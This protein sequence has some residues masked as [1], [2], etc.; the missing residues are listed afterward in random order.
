MARTPTS[1]PPAGAVA[2]DDIRWLDADK[3]YALS[4]DGGKLVCRNPGGKRLS[5]VPKEL[6]ESALAEQLTAL[7]EWLADHRTE[8]LRRVETWMLRSLPVPCDVVR[9]VW[10]DPDW[11]D[12]LRN[13]VVAPVD[14]K[15]RTDATRTGLF[16]DVDPK[17][18]VGVVDRDGETKWLAAAQLL[19]PHPIL[20][21]GVGELREIAAD[22]GF[23][24]AL[25]QLFRPIFCADRRATGADANRGL[26][27]WEIRAA[28]LCVVAVPAARLSRARRL[29]L[30]QGLGERQA[31]RGAL[32]D[33]RRISG[34]G[35]VHRRPYFCGR[36]PEAAEDRQRGPRDLQRGDEDGHADF[37]EAH[38]REAGRRRRMS[39][40]IAQL[41][42]GGLVPAGV[43][44]DADATEQIAARSYRHPALGDR[45]VIRLTSDRLGQAE[46]LAMEFLGFA[47]PAVSEP[48]ARQQRRSLGFAAWAL[49]N[50]PANARYALDLVKR[51]KAAARQARSKPGHAWD[52]Y[53]EMAKELGKSVRQFLPPFWEE[54]G[55]TFKDIGNQTYAGRALNKSLEAERV[56][57]LESDRARRRDVVLEFVLSGCL[58]GSAL[59]D[60]GN[61]LLNHYPAAEAFAIFRDLCVRRTRGGMAPWATLPKDFAKLAGAA[62]LDADQELERW[63]EEVIEAPAMGRTPHQFWKT[64][65]SHCKRIVARNPAFAVA[66][67]RHTRPE[68]RH[69]GESKLGPWFELL[70]EWGVLDYLWQDEHRGAPPLGEPIAHW[71]ARIVHDEVPAPERT[72]EMLEK[73]APRLRGEDAAPARRCPALRGRRD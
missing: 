23:T 15:G 65:S 61:D 45:P 44:G 9:A 60:Y 70:E 37:R 13:L 1:P 36:K 16:R 42:A 27:Q 71:F 51:M 31:D 11:R 47:A 26:Q 33:R 35:N 22:M 25:E 34:S 73:L 62:E 32:L 48:I 6:K 20:I 72:L 55:R 54:V 12:M 50:D 17:K 43:K 4:I 5:S 56:H 7:C 66:L 39:T 38:G 14:A 67:L 29:R 8:C 10:P 18:G 57:A 19:I 41:D 49:I 40:V 30:H 3:K 52:A 64:C 59:S 68:A 24:Q 69:Y 28:Q 46:D 21:D 63:L 2:V 53:T 58:A